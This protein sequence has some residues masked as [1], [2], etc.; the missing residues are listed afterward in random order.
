MSHAAEHRED[1][2]QPIVLVVEDEPLIRMAMAAAFRRAGLTVIEAC[3]AAEA[4][5][6]VH[7]G[8]EPDALLTDILM[9]GPIDGLRLAALL[10]ATFP[11]MEV[12][13]SSGYLSGS[14]LK[15]RLNFIPKPTEPDAVAR[16]IKYVLMRGKPEVGPQPD[17]RL[18]D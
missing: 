12:F 15:L 7:T 8:V 5:D 4:L 17:W 18:P 3:D 2:R 10:E 13:V 9:P 1:W 11:S 16:A 6:I 14:D